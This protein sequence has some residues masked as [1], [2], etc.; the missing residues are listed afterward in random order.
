MGKYAITADNRI[1]NNNNIQ[2]D[3]AETTLFNSK[4]NNLLI[5]NSFLQISDRA[6]SGNIH[7]YRS[8]IRGSSFLEPGMTGF[9]DR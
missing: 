2:V 8:S 5:Y 7:R 4:F 9:F 3:L 1:K 6:L